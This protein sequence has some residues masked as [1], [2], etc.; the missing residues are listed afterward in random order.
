MC[1]SALTRD[2]R[3]YSWRHDL[4]ALPGDLVPVGRAVEPGCD[5]G[6]G[7]VVDRTVDVFA[8][9]GLDPAKYLVAERAVWS[10]T[11]DP[12]RRPSGGSCAPPPATPTE[13]RPWKAQ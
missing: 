11:D 12:C 3:T 2:G 10:T 7:P 9:P 8:L 1:S 4:A 6:G 13:T 5:D